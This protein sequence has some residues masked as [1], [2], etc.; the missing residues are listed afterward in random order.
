MTKY[1]DF[2]V[3]S[4]TWI[5]FLC[6]EFMDNGAKQF[7]MA[8][9]KKKQLERSISDLETA[10]EDMTNGISISIHGLLHSRRA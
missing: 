9:D 2:L 8:E 7:D 10:I 3:I 4:A 5:F 6:I 1:G